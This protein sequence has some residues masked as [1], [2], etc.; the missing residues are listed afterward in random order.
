MR[1]A[2]FQQFAIA[3]YQA[4]GLQAE[5]WTEGTTRPFGVKVRLPGGAEIWHAITTQPRDGDRQE[6]PEQP[7]EKEAPH[8]VD[9]PELPAGRAPVAAVERYLAAL[10]S[11]AGSA[12]VSRVYGYSDREQSGSTA[13]FGVEFWSGAKAFAPFVHAM[14]PGQTSPGQEFD[15]PR[16]V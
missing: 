10:I 1:P 14:R 15:L 13:G 4:A 2:R 6:E 8:P 16:E 9:V 5:P 3:A 11:N 12:E 7:V